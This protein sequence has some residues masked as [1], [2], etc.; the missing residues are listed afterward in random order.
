MKKIKYLSLG[1]LCYDF[2]SYYVFSICIATS[3]AIVPVGK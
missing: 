3:R 2:Y 1:W